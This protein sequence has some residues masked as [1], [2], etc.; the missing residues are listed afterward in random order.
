MADSIDLSLSNYKNEGFKMP[1]KDNNDTSKNPK[2]LINENIKD[3][4][5]IFFEKQKVVTPL[6][7]EEIH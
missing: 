2:V 5:L 7:F 1:E 6:D 3:L 4:N